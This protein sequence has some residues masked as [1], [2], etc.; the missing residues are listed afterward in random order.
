MNYIICSL[1]ACINNSD[2]EIRKFQNIVTTMCRQGKSCDLFDCS[3][4]KSLSSIR[5]HFIYLHCVNED[6]LQKMRKY[7]AVSSMTLSTW[8]VYGALGIPTE[9]T[10]APHFDVSG[11]KIES[12]RTK[13]IWLTASPSQD[14][15]HLTDCFIITAQ[16]SS[17][18]PL[19]KQRTQVISLTTSSSQVKGHLTDCFIMTGQRSSD[20]LL[21]HDRSNVIWLTASSWQ[22]K[23]HLTDCFIMTGQMS[24]DW[25]LH[26]DRSNVIWLTAS[27]SPV[28]CHLT[29]CFIMTGQMSSD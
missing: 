3:I 7:F 29:D 5:N 26:H 10:N 27:S 13:V 24:S 6:K 20:W 18:W 4:Y 12:N 22:V 28:K 25:L 19:H 15:G 8:S 2:A 14:K 21:H 16:R 23:C 17:H 11:I 9:V 1:V